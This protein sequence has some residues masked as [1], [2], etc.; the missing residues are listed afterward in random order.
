MALDKYIAKRYKNITT[1]SI[2][3]TED[4]LEL[5]LLKD[6]ERAKKSSDAMGAVGIFLSLFI[7]VLT[8]DNYK[9]FIGI[10]SDTWLILFIIALI[11]SFLYMLYSIFSYYKNKIDVYDII[12]HIKEKSDI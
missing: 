12:N 10:S 8:T 11:A 3:I 1:S 9:D 7:A 5:V 2:E 4:K 6:F